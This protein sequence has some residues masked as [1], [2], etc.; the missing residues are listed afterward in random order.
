M[1]GPQRLASASQSAPRPL[2]AAEMRTLGL[3]VALDRTGFSPGEIDAVAG[4]NTDKALRAFQAARGLDVTV[5]LDP[6]TEAALGEGIQSP[7]TS[8]V[9]GADAV[10]ATFV[11]IP[12]DMMA[13]AELSELGY[14]SVAELI[15]ER[16]HASPSLIERLNPG[17][18]FENG[19]ELRVPNVEPLVIP[20]AIGHARKPA[21]KNEALTVTVSAA[22][23]T[24][25]VLDAEGAVRFYAPVSLGSERDPLPT[26]DFTVSGIKVNPVFY[27][28]PDLFWDADPSHARAKIAPGPNNPVGFVWVDLNRDHL[29]IHGTPRPSTVGKTQSHG[30]IRLTNW[31]ALRL[32]ALIGK[33]T[34]VVLG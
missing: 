31:D 9:I 10:S 26:G 6:S 8:Y 16:F 30:C 33:G 27:Y 17:V 11:R 14:E 12:S 34:R 13:Q 32:A 25:T 21:P 18:P 29:G 20:E 24:L 5:R 2:D 15:A 19:R 23:R 4:E 28:N 3:Q 7:L 1:T 22:A